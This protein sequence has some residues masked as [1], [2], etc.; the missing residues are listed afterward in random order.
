MLQI[1]REALAVLDARPTPR[2]A[3]MQLVSGNEVGISA[4]LLGDFSEI[5]DCRRSLQARRAAPGPAIGIEGSVNPVDVPTGM[6]QTF[7]VVLAAGHGTDDGALLGNDMQRTAGMTLAVGTQDGS[8]GAV[9]RIGDVAKLKTRV[10]V[11][12]A[13]IGPAV[14]LGLAVRFSDGVFHGLYLSYRDY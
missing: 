8:G 11:A 5:K 7:S 13:P 9:V 2:T 6:I 4:G 14:G 12:Q 10:E 3:R 1:V